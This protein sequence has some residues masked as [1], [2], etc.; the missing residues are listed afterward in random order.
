VLLGLYFGQFRARL[1]GVSWLILGPIWL[2][3]L[4]LL[5]VALTGLL[6]ATL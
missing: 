4:Y 2:A 1:R 6:P 3:G 5:F